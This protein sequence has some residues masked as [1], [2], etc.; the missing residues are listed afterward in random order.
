MEKELSVKEA[1]DAYLNAGTITEQQKNDIIAR[2]QDDGLVDDE[3]SEQLSRLFS[4]IESGKLQIVTKGTLAKAK[5]NRAPIKPCRTE[6]AAL[7]AEAL[8][9][10]NKTPQPLEKESLDENTS[11]PEPVKAT[12]PAATSKKETVALS[13]SSGYASLIDGFY[14]QQQKF[15]GEHVFELETDRFL[16]VG[17]NGSIWLKTGA[18]AA[19]HGIVKFTREGILEHGAAKLLKKSLTS[20]GAKLTKA[21][22]QGSVYLA[23]QGKK[24][25][26]INLNGESLVVRGS[27]LLA[28]ETSVNWDIIFMKS[29]AS[30]LAGG[31]FNVRLAGKGAIAV[32]THFDPI[33]LEVSGAQPIMTDAGATVAWSGNLSPQ[34]K[35]DISAK[36]LVGRGSGESIQM[37]FRGDGFV[38]IQPYEEEFIKKV[39]NPSKKK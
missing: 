6:F 1:I 36:T 22:G 14:Q 23:D 33:V 12:S 7:K 21:T 10:Q 32:S 8:E 31:L 5:K 9:R 19:Y 27:D 24:I 20:E 2:I 34:F 15:V 28:F 17:L 3:E 35:T 16:K 30:W 25:N 4:L 29:A 18:M 11:A 13:E 39:D 26:I 38:V 37:A